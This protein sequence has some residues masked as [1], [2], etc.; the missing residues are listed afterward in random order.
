MKRYISKTIAWLAI[1]F[2]LLHHYCTRQ[3][4]YV[5]GTFINKEGVRM[6]CKTVFFTSMNR[7]PLHNLSKAMGESFGVDE[8][9]ILNFHQIPWSM[10]RYIENEDENTL[11]E[12]VEPPW[13][14]QT[15]D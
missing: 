5:T 8:V 14:K 13:K 15:N 10:G 6:F 9:L 7:L 11:I 1:P 4:F 2:L 3:C 12:M